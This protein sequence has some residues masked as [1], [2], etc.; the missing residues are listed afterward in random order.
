[1]RMPMMARRDSMASVRSE[2]SILR[3]RWVAGAIGSSPA[4]MESPSLF[5]RAAKS[6]GCLRKST[7]N[8]AMNEDR[9]QDSCEAVASDASP[10]AS[11]GGRRLRHRLDRPPGPIDAP[12]QPS[13]G[14]LAFDYLWHSIIGLMDQECL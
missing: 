3:T 11:G 10:G 7:V 8:P 14:P 9:W 12:R 5:C 1:M 6:H 2:A 4:I 13:Y